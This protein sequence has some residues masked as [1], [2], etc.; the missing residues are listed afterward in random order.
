M[1]DEEL[2]FRKW[3]RSLEDQPAEV[4]GADQWNQVV[5]EETVDYVFGLSK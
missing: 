3:L 1:D 4:A 2:E 5:I